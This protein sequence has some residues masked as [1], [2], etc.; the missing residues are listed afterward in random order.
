MGGARNLTW[1]KDLK[2]REKLFTESFKTKLRNEFL[3]SADGIQILSEQLTIVVVNS[4]P[5]GMS[6]QPVIFGPIE[7][8]NLTNQALKQLRQAKEK[9]KKSSE[10]FKTL[11]FEE[12]EGSPKLDANQLI[13]QRINNL[14]KDINSLIILLVFS[15]K[16]G[17]LEPILPYA[18]NKPDK[19]SNKLKPH[20]KRSAA[21]EVCFNCLA[22]EGLRLGYST[23]SKSRQGPT[24]RFVQAV[25]CEL[26][27]PGS[28]INADT[29]RTDLRKWQ[30]NRKKQEEL[31]KLIESIGL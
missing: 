5:L 26:T 17:R 3:I 30:E 22:R 1:R 6:I 25:L 19:R 23:S 29:I 12:A 31:E 10:L 20:E 28:Q 21:V 2:A 9:L 14:Q 13:E 27:Q 11:R 16:S 15:I 18:T 24:I 8:R 4:S 7:G